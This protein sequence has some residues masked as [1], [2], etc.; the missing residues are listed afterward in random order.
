[1]I[2]AG[3]LDRLIDERGA[4]ALA[5]TEEME[6]R[7]P[8]LFDRYPRDGR[9]RCTEDTA[10]HIEHLAAALE[11]GDQGIFNDYVKWLVNL[12][13]ARDIPTDDIKVNFEVLADVLL[14]RY[15]D[16]MNPAASLLRDSIPRSARWGTADEPA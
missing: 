6:R 1:M 9:A 5:T 3:W 11:V 12:L 14:E 15:G 8:E 2:D 7:D 10:F 16:P 4:T 13:T